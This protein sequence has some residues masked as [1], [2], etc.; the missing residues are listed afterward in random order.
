M[1]G[2]PRENGLS[3]QVGAI[4]RLLQAQLLVTM[5]LRQTIEAPL[6]QVAE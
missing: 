3:E 4:S 1:P 5:A 2:R 6:R